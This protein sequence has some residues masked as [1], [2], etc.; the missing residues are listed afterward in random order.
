M[1]APFIAEI[2]MFGFDFPPR[3]RSSMNGQILSIARNDFR[4]RSASP[5]QLHT[6]TPNTFLPE[7]ILYSL[8]DRRWRTI[9]RGRH[10]Q[11]RVVISQILQQ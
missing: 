6:M 2:K 1:T 5:R 7:A 11:P 8:P 3:G 4:R 10:L 9:Q